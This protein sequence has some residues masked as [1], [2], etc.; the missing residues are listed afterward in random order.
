MLCI[1]AL[2]AGI[3]LFSNR[4]QVTPDDP[5]VVLAGKTLLDHVNTRRASQCGGAPFSG[6]T[7][8]N[9]ARY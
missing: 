1:A 8:V 4:W 5:V 7:R 9:F 6:V 3:P 2:E